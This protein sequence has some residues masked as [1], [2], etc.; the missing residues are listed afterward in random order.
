MF[1]N[2]K[3]PTLWKVAAF[4]VSQACF[5]PAL[6]APA[7]GS[8]GKGYTVK[9]GDT[10]AKIARTHHVPL[11]DLLRAN[12]VSTPNHIEL[13][14]RIV[15][16]GG[17]GATAKPGKTA[18]KVTG[19]KT[20]TA[21]AS[22]KSNGAKIASSRDRQLESG[23]RTAGSGIASSG[24]T[25]E[26]R[27]TTVDITPPPVAGTYTV[28]SGDSL[29]RIGR[30]T[31]TSMATLMKLNG[32][33][34]SSI[35]RPGQTLRLN[36]GSRTAVAKNQPGTRETERGREP[37]ELQTEEP[38]P[39]ITAPETPRI[40]EQPAATAPDTVAPAP[41][42]SATAPHKVEPGDTFSS[43]GRLYK[44]SQSRLIAANPG[45]KP[46]KL[47][48][49]QTI[50][51]PGQPVRPGAQPV[52]VRADGRILANRPDPLG[53]ATPISMPSERTR[54]GYLVEEGETL[55]QIAQRFH[56][57]ERE[58]RQMNRLGESDNIYA[59]R[60]ILVP[61]IRQAPAGNTY[62]RRDA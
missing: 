7:K 40:Q 34:E 62:A 10:F 58:L 25:G 13:G 50:M 39:V 32:L 49:G 19:A 16:P 11:A 31:G 17:S 51:I 30:R 21:F 20:A 15:I 56:T 2:M 8:S 22:G 41:P 47:R 42:P 44:V 24:R 9:S 55:T 27:S 18:S 4:L 12:R 33:K 48:A 1:G 60:Y 28:K 14:Q 52:V 36:A 43:I 29:E 38:S 35:I 3:Y 26:K 61:F 57:S 37:K 5:T 6:A 45:V 23:S 53:A 59:G 54:T 46:G